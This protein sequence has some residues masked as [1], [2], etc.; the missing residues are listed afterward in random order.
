M[1]SSAGPKSVVG[2]NRAKLTFF[3]RENDVREE[4]MGGSMVQKG[5]FKERLLQV[6]SVAT[7]VAISHRVQR[8]SLSLRGRQ[9][10]EGRS[11]GLAS[12]TPTPIYVWGWSVDAHYY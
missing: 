7:Q 9:Q 8:Y 4:E 5:F 1:A 11:A 6:I 3:S 2:S 12:T 10:E